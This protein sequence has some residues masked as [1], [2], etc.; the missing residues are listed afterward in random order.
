MRVLIPVHLF[1]QTADMGALMSLRR[2]TIS[3][4]VEDAAQ[5]I[6]SEDANEGRNAASMGDIGCFSFFPSKNLGAFG[7][8]GMCVT[9][10]ADARGETERPAAARRQAEVLPRHDRR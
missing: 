6:G 4:V 10:D 3:Q 8:G 9:N 7:D 5:A 2:N 1:G